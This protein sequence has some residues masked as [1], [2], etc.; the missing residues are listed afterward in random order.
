MG[1]LGAPLVLAQD[2]IIRVD[3][4]LV[5]ITFSVRNKQGGLVGNLEEADFEVYEDGKLEKIVRFERENALPLTIG[6]LL[7]TSG[8]MF[9]VLDAARH[10]ASQFFAKVLREKDLAF[11]IT[12]AS[13]MELLQDLTSSQKLLAQGLEEVRGERPTRVM[14]QGPVPTTPR[15]TRLYDAVYLAAN[16][17]LKNETGRKVIVLI[18]DGADQGSYYKF[19]DALK[20]S[21]LADAVVYGFFYAERGY[22]SD[23]GTMKKFSSETGGRVVDVTRRGALEQAFAQLEEEMRSQYSLAYSPSNQNRDGAFRKIEIK[24]RQRD[25]KVQARRG[26]YAP[27]G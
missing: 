17:K 8:S 21:H 16:E 14:V 10:T 24:T 22:Y 11:L 6:L 15:G 25:L 7:D 19:Q 3:V 18:S 23:M 1:L 27:E 20:Q 26:Y 5:N 13:E 12:F 4:E 2:P 9:G